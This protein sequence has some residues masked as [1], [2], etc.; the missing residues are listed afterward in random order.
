MV[1][2]VCDIGFASR[3]AE[4]LRDKGWH[5]LSQAELGK[6]FGCN[7]GMAGRYLKG[8]DKPRG[9][10]RDAL[11]ISLGVCSEWLYTGR[12]PKTPGTADADTLDLSGLSSDAKAA[13]RALRDS[14]KK[15]KAS[16]D[17]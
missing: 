16:N 11:A 4:A 13:L 6:H 3:L 10:K 7:Q 9:S 14:L 5:G 2:K 8:S 15:Q 12:G 1:D 17:H